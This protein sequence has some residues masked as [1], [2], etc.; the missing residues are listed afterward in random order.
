MLIY[1]DNAESPLTA[2]PKHFRELLTRLFESNPKVYILVSSRNSI[3]GGIPGTAERV[4]TLCRLSATV[5]AE[6][7][8]RSA[9]RRLRLEE[10]QDEKLCSNTDPL[11]MLSKRPIIKMLEGHPQAIVLSSA[12]LQ[13]KSLQ[14]VEKMFRN[15]NFNSSLQI[16]D[17]SESQRSSSDTLRTSLQMSLNLIQKG[18]DKIESD[19]TIHMFCVLGLLKGGA[20]LSDLEFVCKKHSKHLDW[21]QSIDRLVRASLIEIEG[22][23]YRTW[24]SSVSSRMSLRVGLWRSLEKL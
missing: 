9:P 17:I 11:T 1:L 21:K 18:E 16:V 14:E 4:Y 12:L 13:D 7:L 24:C 5:S 6:L 3:G 20:Y 22:N 15:G 8:C 19:H 23:F 2:C 10:I